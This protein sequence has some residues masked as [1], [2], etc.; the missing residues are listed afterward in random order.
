MARS[1]RA[2]DHRAR[3][4]VV[5]AALVASV[6]GATPATAVPTATALPAAVPAAV[7]PGDQ[8]DITP[9]WRTVPRQAAV[10]AVS[11]GGYAH[12]TEDADEHFGGEL[13]WT[14]FA[15]GETTSLGYG[16]GN[17]AFAET[18]VGGRYAYVER[19]AGNRY[20]RDLATGTEQPLTLPRDA[21]YR[22]LLG[23]TLL[24]QQYESEESSQ[25]T[26]G[27]YLRRAGDATGTKIPVTGFPEDANLHMARLVAGDDTAAVIRFGRGDDA[28]NPTDLGVVDLRTGQMTVIEAPTSV[29]ASILVAPVALSADRIAW[30]DRNRQVH[31]RERS[32]LTGAERTFALP[33]GLSSARIGL[34]GD[35][36][37]AVDEASGTDASLKRRLV[38]LS[39]DG[40]PQ[41][42]LEKTEPEINQIVGGVGAAVVGGSSATDWFL[43]KAVPGKGG[44]APVLEKLRRVEPLATA[45]QS[46]ALGAG[47]LSTLER[48]GQLGRGFFARNLPVGPLHTGQ[49][50]PVSVGSEERLE[51]TTPLFDSGDGRTVHLARG[52]VGGMEVVGRRSAKETTRAA[53]GKSSARLADASGRW[54]VVQGGRPSI[55]GELVAGEETL[56]VDLDAAPGAPS[57]VRRQPQTAAA[58]RG[59]TLFAGTDTVGQVSRTDLATGKDLG[60]VATGA[61][62]RATELQVAGRWLY[63]A[64]AQ[65]SAQGVVDLQDTNTKIA[66]PRGSY[67]GGLLGDGFVVD[68][69]PGSYLRL[70]DFHTGT[71]AAARTLVDSAPVQG[72]RRETWTVDRF[73]GAVAYKDAE[74]RIHAVWTGVRTSDLTATA[75]STPTSAR[76]TDGWKAAWSLSKPASY[77]QLTLRRKVN[78]AVVRTYDGGETRGRIA[79]GWDGKDAAGRLVTDGTFT[80]TLT[81]NTADGESLDLSASGVV[82]VTGGR[83]LPW[84][85]LAGNDGF[86]DLL[87]MDSTGLVS[88]YRGNGSGGLAARTN[89]TGGKLPTTA[90]LVPVGDMTGDGCNDVYGRVGDELRGY[91]TGCGAI[92]SDSSAYT[93]VGRG[94]GQYDVVTSSG[95]VNGDGWK[96]LIARQASTGDL[97]FY[98][99]TEDARLGTRVKIGTN[100][101][102]YK[103]IVGAGDLNGDGRGDLLGLDA[104]GVLWRYYGTANGGLTPRVKVGGGWGVYNSL[105]SVGDITGDGRAELL[106]RDTTGKLWRYTNLGNGGYAGR[107]MIGSGG[108]NGFKALY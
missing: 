58:L 103:K 107:V 92:V 74:N 21:S 79:V 9:N 76:A 95:D 60:T 10:K 57:V 80:W 33:E 19:G 81:A 39:P 30:V 1:S 45:V 38:A 77:W 28:Y 48:D 75:A 87:V 25:T 23:D 52:S 35:W 84:R 24:F 2:R 97:Y 102:L 16:S 94:W 49:S 20:L 91:R 105:V 65:F 14:D 83:V 89:G 4:A 51:T 68:Q 106:A 13:F 67:S 34:V 71:A 27:Y 59:D 15:S 85:D 12:E 108:W 82:S 72:A 26:T 86:G 11:A 7:P 40:V 78:G 36:V 100:W 53:T 104:A 17:P 42:L 18:G 66:L 93:L 64:C 56:V 31:I 47:R 43:L 44:G 46:L 50:E 54:A 32:A 70:I 63:W 29:G 6:I 8:L 90:L 41:T 98:P 101:K 88:L 69:G 73:G 96:D 61:T 37:L 62:C 55:P 5:A 3:T 22:G 99:G